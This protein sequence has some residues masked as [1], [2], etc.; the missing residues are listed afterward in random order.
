MRF[1]AI[2][3]S[4]LSA[5]WAQDASRLALAHCGVCHRADSPNRAPHPAALAALPAERILASFDKGHAAERR[6]AP[7]QKSLLAR[8]YAARA[9]PVPACAPDRTP[10]TDSSYWN[11]WTNDPAGSRTLPPAIAGLHRAD[12]PKL[13]QTWSRTM[14]GAISQPMVAAGRVYFGDATGGVTSVDAESG[15]AYW[16]FRADAGVSHPVSLGAIHS[17][18]FAALFADDRANV[19]AVDAATGEIDWKTPAASGDHTTTAPPRLH[20]NRI[21]VPMGAGGLAAIHTESG[22]L[23]WRSAEP[24]GSDAP[25]IDARAGIVSTTT[26]SYELAG[27]KRVGAASAPGSPAMTNV[28]GIDLTVS[29]SVV[30]I[31]DPAGPGWRFDASRHGAIRGGAVVAGSTVFAAAGDTLLA[32]R[33]E[34]LA[35][36]A[37]VQVALRTNDGGVIRADEYGGGGRGVVL[38]HGGRFNKGSWVAQARDL[39]ARGFRVLAIDFRGYGQSHAPAEG[40]LH[41]D[42]LA[43]VR[44]LRATGAQSVSVIGG[45]LGGG[46]AADAVVQ[47][48]PGE[49]DRLVMLGTAGGDL[50]PEKIGVP[51]LILIARDDRNGDG[52]RLPGVQ[53]AFAKMPKPKRLVVL[54]GSAHAQFMFETDQA[55]RV[56]QEI[57]TFLN[58]SRVTPPRTSP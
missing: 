14:K 9:T 3:L 43:A 16:T 31:R 50:P 46:A 53:A 35:A 1:P 47:A 10:A 18:R 12:W 21:Y 25:R 11:G 37:A 40:G 26:D 19:Y 5:L 7:E 51:K 44:Y 45:S 56:M 33:P 27:G 22:S 34:H 8:H 49:I 15:C 24:G 36:G 28:A 48:A 6:L 30:E 52:P 13:R 54:D 32:F 42:V 23:V 41:H 55:G 57:A 4:S 38:A 29:G 17:G 58:E 2:V 39:A 20:G